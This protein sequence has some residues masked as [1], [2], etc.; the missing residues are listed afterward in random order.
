MADGQEPRPHL[1]ACPNCSAY[2]ERIRIT[3]QLAGTPEARADI[4]E[5]YRVGDPS[6]TPAG[7]VLHLGTPDI[8]SAPGGLVHAASDLE[9]PVS[10]PRSLGRA[11]Q[12]RLIP[13]LSCS[14]SLVR[15]LRRGATL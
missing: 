9:D 12:G 3:I 6:S 1:R 8:R 2:L 11:D 15:L 7:P 13:P 5:L 10:R 4:R 14:H